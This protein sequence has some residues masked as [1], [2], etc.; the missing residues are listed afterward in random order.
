MSPP[1]REVR[2]SV[3]YDYSDYSQ[4]QLNY[5]DRETMRPFPSTRVYI[6]DELKIMVNSLGGFGPEP[7]PHLPMIGVFGDSV[8]QGSDDSFVDHIHIP[9]CTT[10]N[11]GVEGSDLCQ[12]MNRFCETQTKRPMIAA[13]IH[14]GFHNL[15]YGQTSFAFWERELARLKG[16]PVTAIFRLTAD[17][18]SEAMERGYES[19]FGEDYGRME[20][21]KDMKSLG[22]FK[23]A[24]DRKNKLIEKYVAAGGHLL[25]DLDDVLAPRT[26][27]D[28]SRR[29]F[30]IIHPRQ[31]LYAEIGAAVAAALARAVEQALPNWRSHEQPAPAAAPAAPRDPTLDR[32]RNYPLW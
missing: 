14:A 26:Y 31:H 20:F 19:L 18:N 13:A 9:G 6:G 8:V 23:E 21:N 2:L 4:F 32:G 3:D 24:V 30:D 16:P 1:L 28:I 11:G 29:F 12:T 27:A 5:L 10:L 15:I 22:E 7:E 17:I 25:I